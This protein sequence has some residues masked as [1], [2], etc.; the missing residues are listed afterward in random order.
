MRKNW[1]ASRPCGLLASFSAENSLM[2]LKIR[3]MVVKY[4]QWK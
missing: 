4:A 1:L 2:G 3:Q